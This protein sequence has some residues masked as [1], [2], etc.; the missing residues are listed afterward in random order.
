MF[1]FTVYCKPWKKSSWLFNDPL[2]VVWKLV[3]DFVGTRLLTVSLIPKHTFYTLDHQYVTI[4][5]ILTL[6]L[7]FNL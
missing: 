5:D 4:T 1:D 6:Q 7:S 3:P 2:Q